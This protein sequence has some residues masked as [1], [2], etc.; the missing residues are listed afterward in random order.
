MLRAIRHAIAGL[1]LLSVLLLSHLASAAP[2]YDPQRVKRTSLFVTEGTVEVNG[3]P[4]TVVAYNDSMPGPAMRFHPGD[5]VIVNVTNLTPRNTTVHWHG[6]S[7][8]LSPFSD[9][10]PLS[11]WPIAP[12]NWFEYQMELTKEDVST[13]HPAN[14][15]ANE[16]Q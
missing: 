16:V 6:L 4:N 15:R 7:Q 1:A 8:R 5:V 10:T 2:R 12:G 13:P 14:H 9:G 11:Q 3:I